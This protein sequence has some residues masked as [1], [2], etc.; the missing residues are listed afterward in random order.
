MTSFVPLPPS[1]PPPLSLFPHPVTSPRLSVGFL[2]PLC[3]QAGFPAGE[4]S[5]EDEEE[6]LQCEG[7]PDPHQGDPQEEGCVVLQA[8]GVDSS[9]IIFCDLCPYRAVC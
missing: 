9:L 6:Q 3:C 1:I 7:N 5:E 2:S 4:T 8:A